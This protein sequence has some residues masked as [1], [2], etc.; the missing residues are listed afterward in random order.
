LNVVEIR[1]HRRVWMLALL[2]V[3]SA[4]HPAPSTPNGRMVEYRALE[5]R[6]IPTT[7][8]PAPDGTVWFTIDFSNAIGRIAGGKV[9][10]LVKGKENV[11]PMGLGV[12]ADG[13]AWITDAPQVQ[14]AHVG[15]DGRVD[16]VP[17]ETPIA[18][19]GRLAVGK[20]GAVWFAEST[21][22][23]ITRYAGG[24]LQRHQIDPVR[25][26]PF[27][28]AV[29]ADGS[30]WASLQLGNKIVHVVPG[31]DAVEYELPTASSSPSDVAIGPDGAIW[32]IEFRPNQ[33]ARFKDGRFEEYKVEGDRSG[34][35]GLTVGRDGAVWFGLLREHAIGRL[36]AGKVVK[37]PLP[38]PEARPASV[39]VD[40][41][42][43][44]W[45]ADITGWVGMI[46]AATAEAP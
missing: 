4:C 7:V 31:A 40:G 6:D 17:L 19:L 38:R 21:R 20:D 1:R 37:F 32:V 9:E 5:A 12:A 45:Y 14:I 34:L 29:S 35:A 8:A 15:R 18:R 39:A 24:T 13:S 36:R 3:L 42:G 28:V 16:T 26:A 22:N 43:N 23:S 11:E 41:S 30:A 27:G 10:R 33:I 46:P 2:P 44:V 25:G